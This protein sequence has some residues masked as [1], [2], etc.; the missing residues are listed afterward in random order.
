MSLFHI[1]ICRKKVVADEFLAKPKTLGEFSNYGSFH[2]RKGISGGDNGIHQDED[3]VL[4]PTAMVYDDVDRG[5]DG[6]HGFFG[7]R[8]NVLQ[9][10]TSSIT[11]TAAWT[12]LDVSN[13]VCNQALASGKTRISFTVT[14]GHPSSPWTF[15][16]CFYASPYARSIVSLSLNSLILSGNASY[17]DPFVRLASAVSLSLNG[18]EI[19]N[20]RLVTPSGPYTTDWATLFSS[21]PSLRSLT[22]QNMSLTGTLPSHLPAGLR[23]FSLPQNSISGTLPATLFENYV[24]SG[25]VAFNLAVSNNNL[26]GTIPINWIPTQPNAAFSLY[27]SSNQLE[28]AIPPNLLTNLGQVTTLTFNPGFNRFSQPVPHD[29]WGLPHS[30]PNLVLLNYHG[31]GNGLTGT[32]PPDWL[33]NYSTPA[34]TDVY[35]TLSNNRIHGDLPKSVFFPSMP[36]L[37]NLQLVISPGA[38]LNGT[39]ASDLLSQLTSVTYA[40]TKPPTITLQLWSSPLSGTLT[41]PS[42][43]AN[44]PILPTISLDMRSNKLSYLQAEPGAF[45]YL[46]KL[47]VSNNVNL[48]GSLNALFPSSGVTKLRILTAPYTSLSGIMPPMADV[49]TSVLQTL[50]LFGTKIDFCS[51]SRDVWISP[52]PIACTL[53][54]TNSYECASLY[55]NCTSSAPP[56]PIS[57]PTPPPPVSPPASPPVPVTPECSESTRPSPTFICIDGVWTANTSITTPILTIPTGASEVVVSGNVTSQAIVLQGVG[58]SVLVT[59]C[60]TNLTKVTVVLTPEE[61]AKL[62]G[63]SVQQLLSANA[64]CANFTAVSIV[65]QITGSSCRK[66]SVE[67]VQQG[68]NLNAV[69]SVSSSGCNVWWIVLVSVIAGVIIFGTIILLVTLFACKCGPF[70]YRSHSPSSVTDS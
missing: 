41:L 30:L 24:P 38:S 31:G 39:I 56:T 1:T 26:T 11:A 28:G 12:D 51:G 23:S 5:D 2:G 20:S 3:M 44:L 67:K 4:Y 62:P 15:P 70:K 29:F 6:D 25:P 22:L 35:F 57:S 19:L 9:S 32:I 55:P 63:K 59:G 17:T 60:F 40:T 21:F 48:N 42:P 66:V 61:L 13:A 53:N 45:S 69:F 64:S 33:S 54:Y 8:R 50:N 68:S 14:G 43:P 18:L 34:I 37:I 10:S 16:E 7:S 58:S 49:N 47:D 65:P 52:T 36:K 46:H 27:L